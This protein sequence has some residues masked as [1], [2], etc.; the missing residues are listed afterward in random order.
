MVAEEDES[1]RMMIEGGGP[2]KEAQAPVTTPESAYYLRDSPPQT[3]Q[4]EG[5]GIDR[6]SAAGAPPT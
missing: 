3:E 1:G 2:R 5:E 4:R 6:R